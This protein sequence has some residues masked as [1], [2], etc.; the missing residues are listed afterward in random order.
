VVACHRCLRLAEWAG[1][2]PAGAGGRGSPP[3]LVTVNLPFISVEWP[4]KLQK[5]V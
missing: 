3:Y 1:G 2:T 5:N 4:G